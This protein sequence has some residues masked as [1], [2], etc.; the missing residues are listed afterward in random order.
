MQ[1]EARRR[2]SASTA[3]QNM[4]PHRGSVGGPASLQ[5]RYEDLLVS[6]KA[7]TNSAK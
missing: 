5:H 3:Y 1:E 2:P 4:L 7:H 6:P